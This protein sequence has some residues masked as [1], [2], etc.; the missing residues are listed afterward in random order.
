MPFD[1]EKY[2]AHLT[3][4]NLSK[5]KEDQML[6][7]LWRMSE[8]LVDMSITSPL[9]PLQFALTKSVFDSVEETIAL[10][11]KDKPEHSKQNNDKEAS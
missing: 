8:A 1:K 3:P 7:D 11:S 9:Y 5:D 6:D 2:R 10:E 4:L